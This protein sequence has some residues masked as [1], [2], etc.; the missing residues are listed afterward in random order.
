MKLTP[1]EALTV[2]AAELSSVAPGQWKNFLVALELHSSKR[3][4]ECMRAPASEI[5]TAQ[6]RAQEIDFLEKLFSNC[7]VNFERIRVKLG[8]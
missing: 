2:A 8:Q 7:R 4:E 1:D 6:G 5:F 3:R